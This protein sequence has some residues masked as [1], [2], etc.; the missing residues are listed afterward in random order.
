MNL[1]RYICACNGFQGKM[2]FAGENAD[3]LCVC[4]TSGGVC[5]CFKFIIYRFFDLFGFVCHFGSMEH[6]H[7]AYCRKLQLPEWFKQLVDG[8]S[9]AHAHHTF[10]IMS[11]L[12]Q[13]TFAWEFATLHFVCKCT[14]IWWVPGICLVMWT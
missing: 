2:R 3:Q 9:G 4:A 11:F 1:I 12:E 7:W 8:T 5:C 10:R 6:G 13:D 14:Y